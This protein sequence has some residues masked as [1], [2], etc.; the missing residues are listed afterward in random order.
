MLEGCDILSVTDSFSLERS[1]LHI[2]LNIDLFSYAGSAPLF[3]ELNLEVVEGQTIALVGAS[4]SGKSSLITLLAGLHPRPLGGKFKGQ[5]LKN[6]ARADDIGYLC[7]DPGLFLTGFCSTVMEEVGWSLLGR[8]LSVAMVA[9]RVEETLDELEIA[10]LAW[11]NPQELSGGQQQMVALASVWACRPA[12]LLLDEPA[13]RLDLKSRKRLAR[14]VQDLAATHRVAVVWG[15]AF[16]EEVSWCSRLWELTAVEPAAQAKGSSLLELSSLCADGAVYPARA[17]G[18]GSILVEAIE[19][20]P[21]E[22]TAQDEGLIK[23]DGITY[24]PPGQAEPIFERFS[25]KVDSSQ[26]LGLVGS[27]GAG[28]TTL[29]RLMRGLISPQSGSISIA[30]TYVAT[31]DV[32]RLAS[33]I[34]YTFQNPQS[35]FFCSRVDAELLYSG[36]LLGLEYK[37]AKDRLEEAMELFQLEPYAAWHP[38]ELPASPA[39]LLGIALSWYSKARIQILDEP[40][41]RLDHSGR[42]V[43]ERVLDSWQELGVSSILIAHDLNWLAGVCS[44]IAVLDRGKIL[45]EGPAPIVFSQP[46]VVELLGLD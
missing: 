17:P 2:E 23:V 6:S 7:S 15:T 40:I 37:E 1:L 36:E 28:K 14:V 25:W 22:K 16:L 38:R 19:A 31:A 34:A 27:N 3:S 18:A 11:R 5:L 13:T 21:T 32:A 10:H 30:G 35:L 44:K 29:A 20:K 9:R 46:N 33:L 12:C 4:G 24:C 26:C 42:M 43:L 45:A 8:G 39:A 41:A